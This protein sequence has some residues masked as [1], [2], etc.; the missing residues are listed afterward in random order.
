M[1]NKVSLNNYNPNFKSSEQRTNLTPKQKAVVLLSSAAG[2]APVIAVMAKKKGFS[3][4]PANLLKTN[5]KDWALF[6]YSPINKSIEFKGPQI[7]ATATG[8]VIGG[9]IGGAAVDEKSNLKA[10]KREFVNQMLGNV[11][12]PI[13]CVW[14]GSELYGKYANRLEKAMPQIEKT[15]K[16]YKFINKCLKA[17]PNTIGTLAFLAIGIFC[18]N[19]VSNFLNEKIYHRKVDRGIR[20]TDFAPHIDDICMA[21]TMMNSSSEFGSKLARVI[22]LALLVPGYQTGI[23][24]ENTSDLS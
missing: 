9:F 7:I 21:T 16:L 12:T 6:K 18:G 17:A 13:G 20:L 1:I 4:N 3:L 24:Q 14:A 2:M 5:I 15:G 8:S 11:L 23:A 10:K 19:T 22:P